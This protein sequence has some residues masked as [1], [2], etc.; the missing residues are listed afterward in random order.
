MARKKASQSRSVLVS[1]YQP[2][3]TEKKLD[4]MH[5]A[6]YALGSKVRKPTPSEGEKLLPAELQQQE[7]PEVAA[8]KTHVDALHAHF[9]AASKGKK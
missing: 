7:S 5:S 3:P 1:P 6:L 8:A 2:S 9:K 4:E